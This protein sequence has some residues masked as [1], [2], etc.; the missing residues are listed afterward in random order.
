M[1]SITNTKISD[2]SSVRL[3]LAGPDEILEWSHGEVTKP[4][5]INYRT[6]RYEKDGLF[7]EKI[8][9][10]SKDW[11]CYCGKYKR[12]RYKG[13][14][15]DK[16]GVEI[17][18]SIV[19]RERMGHIKLAVPVSHIWFLRGVPSKI[20]LALGLGVQ[21]LE[22]VIY[23]SS[24]IILSV[25]EEERVKAINQLEQEFK[26]KQKEI[27]KN[28]ASDERELKEKQEEL[29]GIYKTSKDELKGIE[30]L[31]IISEVE[32][33]N[34]S[35]RYGQVFTASIGAEAIRRILENIDVKTEIEKLKRDLVDESVPDKKKVLKR[36]KIYKGFIN[37]NLK[38]EW[39]LPTII[40][41]IPPDLRPMV[42][43]DGGRFAT[44]DLN[45]LYRRIINRNNRL[46]KLIEIGAPEVITRNE[47]RMLQ[48]AVDALFDNS[49]RRSQVSVAASTGQRRAL[50]SLADTLKGK[51]GRFRQNLLGKRVDYSGRSV[52]V[53]GPKLKLHQCGIPKKM[54]LELFKPF[55]INKLIERELAYNVRSAG[56]M[57]EGEAE[58]AYDILDEIISSHYVLL[59]RAPTLH[60]LSIQAFQPV[61]IEGKAIQVHPMV[62]SAFNADFDGDQ[63]AVHVP[64]TNKARWESENLML[65][66]KNLLKPASGEPITTPTLDM[67]L[68]CYYIT[69]ITPGVKGEGKIFSSFDE[70]ILA[71]ELGHID[72]RAKIK[73]QRND[74][75][76]ETSVGRIKLNLITPEGVEFINYEMTKKELKLLVGMI[77]G[78]YGKEE[79]AVFVDK[80]KD[81]G[82]ESVTKS[83]IS[84]GMD[85]LMVPAD[86]KEVMNEAEQKVDLVKKQYNMGLLTEE[87]RKS[88]VIEV[89]N[90]A[91]NKITD[92]VRSS[93]DK[94]GP[95]YSMV[96]SKARGSES[97]VVQMSGMKGL[98]AGPTGETIELPIKSSF[99]EGLNVLEYFISTH[100]ARKGMADT[101][102]RTATAGYL[103]RRLVDVAQDVIVREKDCKDKTGAYIF[104]E[105]SDRIGQ[106]FASRVVG[107]VLT[108]DIAD[109]K[110]GEILAAKGDLVNKEQGEKIEKAGVE[111]VKIRSVVTCKTSR[112]V[113]QK[114]YGMDL[115]RGHLVE[116]GQAVGIVAAQAIGEPGTQLTMRTFHIGGIAGSDITQGLPRVE[117]LFEA[118]PPKG[119]ALVSEVDGK[120]LD[121]ES[122]DKVIVVKIETN[123]KL[124]TIKEYQI[125]AG[126]TLRVSEGDLIGKGS[127]LSEGHIDLKKYYKVMGWEEVYRYIVREIQ[128]VYASQGEG[129]NDKHIEVIIRQMFSRIQILKEGNTNFLV[130][131]I[132]ETDEFNEANEGAKKDGG[133]VAKGERL[134]LG[135]TKVALSTESFL[136]AASFMETARV[137]INAAVAGKEDKLRGLKE[138]IIIGKLI[139]AGTGYK[140]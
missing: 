140:K 20:G 132:V 23:F 101:A 122:Q 50:R 41:V 48:E 75:I 34:L 53:V 51:Q 56:K 133:E 46:K 26:A 69:H 77:L 27:N 130:G 2:F 29:K 113:C 79:A 61:L 81:L 3:K 73:V 65:S 37:A 9:G 93:M 17:T 47:K 105:D 138:N 117:E 107:R 45:D 18:R 78:S 86:K 36:I 137:L 139:P 30:K 123:D 62:C 106:S 109:P 1:E 83:G 11:E 90:E 103:T 58:E 43:L 8:F 14:I 66:A 57:V 119:E 100:G 64:L 35:S 4:E 110:T 5:T 31:K 54:A 85:D 87:E 129:I 115:G 97:V 127:Q 118:R 55:I 15:C 134:L 32:Y 131:D 13:I 112:G 89:W 104:K 7:D 102:L 44:S 38:L 120:V 42:A 111:K 49:A 28:F 121:I 67:V 94:E 80:I 124:K 72:V 6:Q 70:A 68:G 52:I 91:K 22:K 40:P 21:D 126:S 63:M 16:C 125:P 12:I 116:I 19:R 92:L 99:K 98:M 128:E 25:S 96:Y 60:R 33:F 76:L 71:Y 114:C 59:N 88:K 84:W 135:I 10:P 82:F 108:E 39:M 24:Y 136:S 95:V 74:E